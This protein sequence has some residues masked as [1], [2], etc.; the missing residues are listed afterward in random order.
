MKYNGSLPSNVRQNVR[1]Q[2]PVF[3]SRYSTC[4]LLFHLVILRFLRMVRAVNDAEL[5]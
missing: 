2:A 1:G 5:A 4:P 3:N